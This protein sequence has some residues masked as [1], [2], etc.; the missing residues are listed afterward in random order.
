VRDSRALPV[1]IGAVA[2]D[3]PSRLVSADA[4]DRFRAVRAAVGVSEDAA[5]LAPETAATLRV[6]DGDSVRIAP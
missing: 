5:T 3:A 1:R 6:V 4:I 2:A